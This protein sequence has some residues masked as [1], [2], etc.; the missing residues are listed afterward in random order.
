[1]TDRDR[2]FKAGLV[3]GPGQLGMSV[4]IQLVPVIDIAKPS[5]KPSAPSTAFII[6]HPHRTLASEE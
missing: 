1:M 4:R 6:I 5:A 2:A 3:S